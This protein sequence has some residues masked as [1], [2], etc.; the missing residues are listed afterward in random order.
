MLYGMQVVKRTF[1]R[2]LVLGWLLFGARADATI[3][4]A[5][6]MVL[7]NP[8]NASADTNNHDHYLIQRTVEAMD[9]SDNL[10]EPNWVSWDLTGS[11]IGSSGRS[12]SF[13]T[14]TNL[15]PNFYRVMTGDYTHSGYD[16]GHMCPSFDRT[17]TTN[18][19]KL[20][21]F[22]SNIVPQTPDNNQ[23]PWESL[24][25]YCQSLAQTNELLIICG[26]SGF[27]G[28][29]INTNGPVFIPAYTWKIAVVVP[30]GSGTAL[31]RITRATRVIAVNVPNIAGIR[32]VAWT[33]YLTSVNVIQTNTGFT[34]F[35]ALPP[36][37][38]TV[39]RAT[40]DGVAGPATPP[41]LTIARA[42]TNI[43]ISWLAPA[44]GYSL[45][46][47]G[48]LTTTNWTAFSGTVNSNS[49]T[50]SVTITP[51]PG[52]LFFRLAHS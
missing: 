9:Y 49:T 46:Q 44:S 5:Y 47:N 1:A 34:F 36:E 8:S 10:G 40:V 24:E 20:V 30:P 16:R 19:N 11:D 3:G 2:G 28:A 41:T 26:P 23:G 17:D 33:N 32:S 7:G 37:V 31:S 6:Q 29:L 21:F 42:G 35:T 43:I 12:P 4:T 13:Y 39:L 25:S 18:D 15:P 27:S 45:Q 38:A 51:S 22:M 52:N 14:D 48:N 50:I